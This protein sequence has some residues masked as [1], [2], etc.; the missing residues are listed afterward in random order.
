MHFREYTN[1]LKVGKVTSTDVT[2]TLTQD[3]H[4]Y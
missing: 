4:L 3:P 1:E 2:K